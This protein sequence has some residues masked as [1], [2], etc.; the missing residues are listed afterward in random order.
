MSRRAVLGALAASGLGALVGIWRTA[1]PS[2]AAPQNAAVATPTASPAAAPST[3]PAP[4]SAAPEPSCGTVV[5]AVGDIVK[6]VATADRTGRLAIRQKPDLVLLLG[7]IQYPNGSSAEFAKGFAPTAWTTLA[8]RTKPAPG[9]HEYLTEGA[10]GY[11]EYFDNPDP[12]YAFDAG[13]GWRGYSL[14]SE[15]GL[16]RQVDWLEA[17][18]AANPDV[19]VVAYW[20]RPRYSSGEVHGSNRAMQPFW[21]A[22]DG[23]I[24][25]VLGG[26][27]HHYE[28]FAPRDGKRQF[29]VGTGSGAHYGFGSVARG[30]EKRI[31]GFAGVLRLTLRDTGYDWA[32][33]DTNDR[34]LDAGRERFERDEPGGQPMALRAAD[35]H[36]SEPVR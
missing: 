24:G 8:E 15:I 27:E 17:D 1:G 16:G 18:L 22:L 34:R 11:Y 35:L 10:A 12:Y 6:E 32:F 14:N 26:H 20:H 21:D 36:G 33:L 29:V 2:D 23:R 19:P 5:V 13:C 4:P 31:T 25:V 3:E 30:S 28:R 9:N 7:D